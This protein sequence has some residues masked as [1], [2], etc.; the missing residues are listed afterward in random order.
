MQ[1]SICT[2]PRGSKC[3]AKRRDVADRSCVGLFLTRNDEI[4][5]MTTSRYMLER[6]SEREKHERNVCNET[7]SKGSKISNA[8]IQISNVL[9]QN[10]HEQNE[11]KGHVKQLKDKIKEQLGAK[12]RAA[13]SSEKNKRATKRT[14]N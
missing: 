7:M 4:T 14:H 10:E 3:H 11:Q 5:A 1:F 12:E 9:G 8:K 13:R 2:S 6:S